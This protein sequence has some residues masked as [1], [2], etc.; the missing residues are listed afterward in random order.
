[1]FVVQVIVRTFCGVRRH[2]TLLRFPY[3]LKKKSNLKKRKISKIILPGLATTDPPVRLHR[4]GPKR[5]K[6]LKE[7]DYFLNTGID[8]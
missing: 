5:A 4:E 3:E 8:R 1:M 2:P 7:R 6:N